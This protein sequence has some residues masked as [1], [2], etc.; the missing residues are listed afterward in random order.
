[1]NTS[2]NTCLLEMA[3]FRKVRLN[4]WKK[5]SDNDMNYG[6]R[7]YPVRKKMCDQKAIQVDFVYTQ[8]Y[9]NGCLLTNY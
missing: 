2:V 1:M 4:L 6:C 8:N 7:K 5:N 3:I 9:C